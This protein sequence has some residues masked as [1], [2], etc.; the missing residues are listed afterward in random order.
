MERIKSIVVDD[1]KK[2]R[3]ILINLL[4]EIAP[5]VE[6]VG[7]A[8][9]VGEAFRLINELHP[10]LVFLDIQM[11]GG[12]GFTLLGMWQEI[13]FDVI[14]VTAFDQYAL[15]AIKY[16]ALDYLLKPVVKEDLQFAVNKAIKNIKHRLNMHQQI[17][18]LLNNLDPKIPDKRIA[19]HVHD[20]VKLININLISY[21]ESDDSYCKIKLV[22][23]ETYTIAKHLKDFE[24]MFFD[25]NDFVRIHKSCMINVMHIKEYSKGEPCI[26]EMKDGKQFEV[27]RR[28]KQEVLERLKN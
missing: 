28:K 6:V 7:E 1:E 26:I 15:N 11:P 23:S 4:N 19:V 10:Q 5:E 21:I 3:T 8:Q 14:F 24:E 27:S 25:N 2:S 13:P 9:G 20:K 16:S 12:N 17:V 18:A 22:T